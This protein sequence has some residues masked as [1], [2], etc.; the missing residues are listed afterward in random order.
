MVGSDQVW[1][2]KYNEGCLEEMFFRFAKD[3]KC[4]KLSYAASFGTDV[5]EFDDTQTKSCKELISK[6]D[7]VSVREPSGIVLCKDKLSVDAVQVLDPT[8]L[9]E[10]QDDLNLIEGTPRLCD[11]HFLAAYILDLNKEL[12][13]RIMRK[14][15]ELHLE[16]LILS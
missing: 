12:K 8:L 5:W 10:K 6:F 9:L 14:A 13:E 16:P 7:L 3:I 11:K 2:P 4:P 1:R 15:E